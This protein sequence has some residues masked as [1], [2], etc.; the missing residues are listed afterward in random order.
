MHIVT[1]TEATLREWIREHRVTWELGPW[2]DMVGHG[3]VAAFHRR[4][5]QLGVQPDR[6][7]NKTSMEGR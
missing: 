5:A 7:A 1:K 2:K 4:P 6:W 3:P